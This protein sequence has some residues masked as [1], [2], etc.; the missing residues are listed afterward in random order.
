MATEKKILIAEDER[1]LAR[2]L[3]LKLQKE[4]IGSDIA[5]DGIEVKQ[6][7]DA[8]GYAMILMDLMMPHHDGF[9][10]IESMKQKGDTTPVII[11]SNLSQD[12]D[13]N[14][15]ALAG[16]KKYFVK[17]DITLADIVAY[18]KETIGA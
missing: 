2:A 17:S 10:V 6:R 15:A 1:P 11:L 7:I 3:S 4:G 12:S 9:A 5:S 16:A 8:G 13:R 18:V 14:R